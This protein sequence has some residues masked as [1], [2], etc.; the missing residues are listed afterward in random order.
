MVVSFIPFSSPYETL[1]ATFRRFT[2]YR[3]PY[4]C[5]P[6]DLRLNINTIIITIIIIINLTAN[7]LSCGGSGYN[8]CT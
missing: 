6:H 2:F 3:T 5:I 1:D 7:G 4:F 8:A